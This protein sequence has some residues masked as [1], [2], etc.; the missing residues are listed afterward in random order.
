MFGFRCVRV[1]RALKLRAKLSKI[2]DTINRY[3]AEVGLYAVVLLIFFASSMQFFEGFSQ[4]YPFHTWL[5][6][7]FV[8]IATVGYGDIS[9]STA[10][11]RFAAMAMIGF[12]IIS[13]PKMTNE[14]IEKMN[15]QTVYMRAV[16]TPKSRSARH[17][18]MCGDISS[19]SLNGFFAELFH[20][21]HENV[22]LNVVIL[23]PQA[24]TVEIIMLL[25]N[26]NYSMN[27]NYLEG[28]A[29]IDKDLKRARLD[30]ASAIFILTNKFSSD[31]DE[32]DSKSILLNMSIKRYLNAMRIFNSKQM[33]CMQ[34]KSI[35]SSYKFRMQNSRSSLF[36]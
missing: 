30:V 22:D 36:P 12:A 33:Y 14:L 29:L 23:L 9:P 18:I 15:L 25:Q 34:V 6:Y 35:L 31:P 4:N 27:L 7:I 11:G 5:Y 10:A 1:L 16:Y 3:L 2:S 8:T 13:V 17:I 19:I 21:D 26:S 32:E 28:S 24:P 20:E